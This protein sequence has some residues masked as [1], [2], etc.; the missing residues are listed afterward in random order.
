MNDLEKMKIE[1]L[2]NEGYG[3]TRVA[4]ILG[5]NENSVKTY[6]KRHG[7]GG[8]LSK[9]ATVK[10]SRGHKCYFCGVAVVQQKGR[11]PKKFCSDR[12][13]NKWWN[14]HMEL[15]NKKAYHEHECAYCKKTFTVYGKTDRKYCC[16]E[17]YIE[18]R[19]GGKRNGL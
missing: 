11:K 3:Y 9:Q 10:E 16:H 12:C 13:R 17:C 14:S 19:F 1:E 4:R 18:D 2:R 8:N 7:L 15:V 6:C 5:L